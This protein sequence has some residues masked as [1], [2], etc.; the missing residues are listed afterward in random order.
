MAE[1]AGPL[2][3]DRA[4][5][6]LEAQPTLV[7]Q[8]SATVVMNVQSLVD[9]FGP[10]AAVQAIVVDERNAWIHTSPVLVR[11]AMACF[12]ELLGPVCGDFVP[13]STSWFTLA[14]MGT[15]VAT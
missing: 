1:L 9:F 10:D 3:L 4:A 7:E 11:E 15:V 2:G 13:V 6:V 8:F 14:H 5:A 12:V